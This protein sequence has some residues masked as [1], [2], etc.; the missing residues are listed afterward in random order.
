MRHY[1]DVQDR[2]LI[3]PS[4]VYSYTLPF[5]FMQ[6]TFDRKSIIAYECKIHRRNM[7]SK[8]SN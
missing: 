5:I 6:H 7:S 1:E 8:K 3:K 4:H 2:V